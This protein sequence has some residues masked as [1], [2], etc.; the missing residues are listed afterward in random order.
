MSSD[1]HPNELLLTRV[2]NA[3][4]KLVWEAWTQSEHIASWYGPEGFT[5]RVERNDFRQGGQWRFVMIG[6]DKAE[7]PSEGVYQQIV[8]YERYVSTDDFAEDYD[9]INK[10]KLPAAMVVTTIFEDIGDKTRVSIRIMH[11]TLEDKRRHEEMGVI[12]GWNSMMDK[13]EPYL[14]QL[15]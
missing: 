8:P 7:Y 13:L 14:A 6:P 11:P 1:L 9:A 5:T 2:F 4:R 10:D 15:A 12:A 3:P